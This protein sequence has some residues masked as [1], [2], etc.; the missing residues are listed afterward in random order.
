MRPLLRRLWF[1]LTESRRDADLREEIETH[2]QL[3]QAQ[4][5]RDGLSPAAAADLSRRALG[6]VTLA[7]ED[8][9][10]TW[11]AAWIESAAQDLRIALRGLRKSRTFTLVAVATLA[12]GIGANTALFS[13]FNSLLLRQLPVREPERLALLDRGSFTYPIWEAFEANTGAVF[14]GAFAWAAGEFDLSPGGLTDPMPGAYVSGRFFDVLGVSPALGRLIGPGDDRLDG[15]AG[16]AVIS[17]RAWRERFDGAPTIVGTAISVN[18]HPFTVVGVMPPGFAGLEVGRTADVVIPMA[19][20]PILRGADSALRHRTAWWLQIM[21]RLKSGVTLTQANAALRAVQPAIRDASKP[22]RESHFLEE[23]FT[24]VPAAT[25]RSPLRRTFETPLRAML[26]TVGAVLLIACANLTNLLVG[27]ALARRRE[28]SVRL[29]LGASRWRMARLL[30]FETVVLVV[31]GALLGLLFARWS[32]A[33]LVQQLS[34]WRG[35]VMLDLTLDWRVL[36]FTIGIGAATAIVAGLLPAFTVTGVAPGDALKDSARTIAGDRRLSLRGA[37]VVA[38][39][40]LSLLLVVGAGLFLRTFGALTRVPLGFE[41]A[42]LSVVRIDLSS[43]GVSAD[44]RPAL[45]ERIHHAVSAAPGVQSSSLS[46][47]TPI[48]GSGWNEYVGGASDEGRR[49]QA[50][51]NAVTPDWF[52]TMGIRQLAGR[53]F[54]RGDRVG[55]APVA[56][57]NEMFVG[58]FL[59]G[60]SPVGRRLHIGKPTDGTDYEIVGVVSDAVYKSLREGVLPTMYLPLAQEKRIGQGIGL[61]VKA[62]GT[63]GATDR[64]VADALHEVDPGLSFSFVD[65]DQF[66]QAGMT[67]ERLVA[68]LSAFFGGLALLLA[69]VGLYGIVAH[70]VDVRRTEIGL[71]MALGAGRTGILWLVF[72]RVGVLLLLGLGAGLALSL[73]ASRFVG[74][75]L[76]QLEPRDATTFAGALVVLVAASILAAW[77]PARRA[78]LVDPATVLREG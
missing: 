74:S 21:G 30:A 27:R 59:P 2:R 5:E 76:F 67:Q 35:A 70:A 44:D 69:A 57:V 56:I 73:W 53:T 11:S 37:L 22:E 77:L 50:W 9:R 61:T 32:S 13:I 20:E 65:F 78:S 63:R 66:K 45:L 64:V 29:A 42:P 46:V 4:L 40:A 41:P 3:R 36:A 43:A 15:N 26:A 72:R 75:L 51:I 68:L 14:D 49:P 34:T 71:R 55:G 60:G 48:T 7:R 38:Q 19:A 18:R 16:V 24:L 10:D 6:N 25:G 28:L 8:A 62:G 12:L 47:I 52:A 33:I 39:L 58:R 23:P 54:D 31:G 1:R 17:Y